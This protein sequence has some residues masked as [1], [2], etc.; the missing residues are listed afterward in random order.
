M[1][2][3]ISRIEIIE[4]KTNQIWI[5]DSHISHTLLN[6]SY[7]FHVVGNNTGDV[8]GIICISHFSENEIIRKKFTWFELRRNQNNSEV[9]WEQHVAWRDVDVIP[10]SLRYIQCI[11]GLLYHH[12][13]DENDVQSRGIPP[14]L[15]NNTFDPQ[16]LSTVFGRVS[17]DGQCILVCCTAPSCHLSVL[18]SIDRENGTV[19]WLRVIPSPFDPVFFISSPSKVSLFTILCGGEN[20]T[21]ALSKQVIDMN[22]GELISSFNK[23]VKTLIF[24]GPLAYRIRTRN[25]YIE[26]PIDDGRSAPCISIS[27]LKYVSRWINCYFKFL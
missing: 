3:S 6:G 10:S 24:N 20:N 23:I 1:H 15:G 17:T 16:S 11:N 2:R 21:S 12:D 9:S 26:P 7:E 22:S 8:E 25:N 5:L 13:D 18:C 4:F 27:S 14:V 19:F